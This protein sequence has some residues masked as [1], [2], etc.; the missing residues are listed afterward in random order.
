MRHLTGALNQIVTS[1][2]E[3]LLQQLSQDKM[4]ISSRHQN[5]VID[6]S[7]SCSFEK[8]QLNNLFNTVN[9]CNYC[10]HKH[11]K[12]SFIFCTTPLIKSYLEEQDFFPVVFE[13]NYQILWHFFYSTF[14]CSQRETGICK[15]Y[16]FILLFNDHQQYFVKVKSPSV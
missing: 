12:L 10:S 11:Y 14:I 3:A 5:S 7:S 9:S 8:Y 1:Y 13:A 15:I 16:C 6:S 2:G 4:H